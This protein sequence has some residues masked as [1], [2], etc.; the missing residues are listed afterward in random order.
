[1]LSPV[2]EALHALRPKGSSRDETRHAVAALHQAMA[3]QALYGTDFRRSAGLIGT[4]A[5]DVGE[6]LKWWTSHLERSL[7][8]VAR[9]SRET[10]VDV[11]T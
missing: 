5:T 9:P 8:I 10:G 6:H 7:G 2:V 11:E 1:M 4:N 3:L